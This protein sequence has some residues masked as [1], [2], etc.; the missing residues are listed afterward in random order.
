[1]L[2][3][4]A[5][6]GLSAICAVT[7]IHARNPW[8]SIAET[9]IIREGAF[10]ITALFLRRLARGVTTWALVIYGLPKPTRPTKMS[11]WFLG[12]LARGGEGGFALLIL[13]VVISLIYKRLPLSSP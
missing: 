2:P 12:R 13:L 8:Y 9:V 7:L 11:Y 5:R 10:T 4:L 1:M 6:G 3:L